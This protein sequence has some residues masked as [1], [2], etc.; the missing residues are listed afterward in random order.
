MD[1]E[2]IESWVA[3]IPRSKLGEIQADH[4]IWEETDGG[5]HFMVTRHLLSTVGTY[6]I[7]SLSISGEPSERKRVMR[8]F[9]SVLGVP[10]S[11]DIALRQSDHIDLVTWLL[12]VPYE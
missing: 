5:A 10:E 1:K 7:I 12:R 8:E 3:T 11:G 4:E 2:I 6:E 9:N